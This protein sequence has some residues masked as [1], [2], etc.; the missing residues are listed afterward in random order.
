M[1]LLIPG[2]TGTDMNALDVVVRGGEE[3]LRWGGYIE[4]YAGTYEYTT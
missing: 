1:M 2:L 3:W 4:Q